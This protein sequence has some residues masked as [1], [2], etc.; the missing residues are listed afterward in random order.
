MTDVGSSSAWLA[1]PVAA[2]LL[3]A[4]GVALFG[5]R[6]RAVICGMGACGTAAVSMVVLARVVAEGPMRHR[7][8]GWGA[9]LGIDLFADGLSAL[10]LAMTAAVGGAISLYSSAYFERARDRQAF[11]PIWFLLWTGLNALFLTADLFNFYVT[12]EL[13]GLSAVALVAMEGGAVALTAAVRYLFVAMLGSLSYMGGVALVY[14]QTG[15]L[16]LALL[17]GRLGA[18]PLGQAALALLIVG[19]LAKTALFPLHLW[20]PPAHASAPAPVSAALSALV[21][22]ASFYILLRTSF[23]AFADAALA[24]VGPILGAL[25]GAAVLWGSL[26]ALTQDRL[27]LMIAYSTVAQIGYLFLFFPV[28]MPGAGD[29][30]WQSK[31]WIA[32]IFHA[33]SHAAAKGAMFMAA[34]AILHAVGRDD[35]N[36]LRGLGER[37]PVSISALAV[38]GVSIMALPPSGGFIAK[39]M[40]LVAAVRTDQWWWAPLMIGGGLLAA[41]YVFRMLKFAFLATPADAPPLH[42]VP[43]RLEYTALALALVAFALGLASVFPIAVAAIGAPFPEN[44]FTEAL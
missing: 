33:L 36:S 34:G 9:P 35:K 22:K 17:E 12:L 20:L 8:G 30:A 27:K 39:W 6:L 10:M 23:T 25:G 3:A 18:G 38:A 29:A 43:R 42:P 19:L 14:A 21:V 26:Q 1:A 37:M 2:P 5:A 28:A 32:G 7:L 13:I 40:L 15:A 4:I 11:W 16:D 24:A 44:W 41:G 31:A